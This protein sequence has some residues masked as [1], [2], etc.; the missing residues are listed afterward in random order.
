MNVLR[1]GCVAM[2]QARMGSSRLPGKVLMD[3][4]GKP[5]LERVVERVR[6]AFPR[7]RVWV[8]TSAHPY[9]APIEALGRRLGIHVYAS[10]APEEDVLMRYLEA[11][12]H[13]RATG[14]VRVTADN[15]FTDPCSMEEMIELFYS[16]AADCV[17]NDHS[18]GLPSGFCSEVISTEALL[19]CHGNAIKEQREDVTRYLYDHPQE[20][21]IVAWEA[22]PA[23]R[24]RE[25]RLSV[26]TAGD[27]ERAREVFR[28][29]GE[30]ACL[31]APGEILALFDSRG[32]FR[33]W[34]S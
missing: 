18:A 32:N 15:P 19:R 28:R 10:D 5:L 16:Q 24:H 9:N 25:V 8:L 12:R 29:L 13:L 4:E 7:E 34:R 6:R 20:F 14:V 33:P 21:R 11:A 27:L 2:I 22:P 23:L 17:H 31:A 3:L 30:N 26:D 1:N